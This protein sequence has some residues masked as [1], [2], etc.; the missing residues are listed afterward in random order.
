MVDLPYPSVD[1]VQPDLERPGCGALLGELRFKLADL[2]LERAELVVDARAL[3]LDEQVGMQ[4][5]VRAHDP[6]DLRRDRLLVRRRCVAVDG[7]VPGRAATR[8]A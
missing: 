6:D 3:C 8:R 1:L 2:L 4:L 7:R 5:Q